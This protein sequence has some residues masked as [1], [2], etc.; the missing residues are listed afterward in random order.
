M[1]QKHKFNCLAQFIFMKK[2]KRIAIILFSLCWLF[3]AKVSAQFGEAHW[4]SA[5]GV[6]DTANTW[7]GFRKEFTLDRLPDEALASVAADSKY[8][9]WVN[10]ELAVFEGG[11][12]RGP[13]PSD[14]YYDQVDISPYLRVGENVIAIKLWFFGKDGFSHKNSG[15][16]GLIF[17]CEAGGGEFRL[18]SDSDW[19]AKVLA[20]YQ[21]V[22]PP[23]PNFRLPES[24][25]LYD[26]RMADTLWMTAK[27]NAVEFPGAIALGRAG[28]TPWNQL[29]PRPIPMWK[30][31]GLREYERQNGKPYVKK[32]DTLICALPYNAQFTPYLSVRA[33]ADQ[34]IV[35]AT[36]NYLLYNGS[37]ENIR[38]E[39]I[40]RDGLQTYESPGWLNGHRM[41]Y[42][43]PEG[44]EVISLKYRETGY[45][46]DFSGSF[47]SDDPFFNTLW[48]KALRTLYVTMRDN[49]MDCPD[50][51]RAQWTG[52]AV[53][54]AEEAFYALDPSSHA[55]A[56]KWLHE[57]VNWQRPDGSLFSPVPAGN[58]DRELPD[59]VL[60]SIG[61]YGIWTY[62]MHTADIETVRLLYPAI[63]RYL[64]LWERDED[65]LVSIREGGWLWGD[66]GENKDMLLIFN[67][68]YYLALR[69]N[70]LM[71]TELGMADDAARYQQYMSLFEKAF[72]E[73]FW[74]GKVYRDPKYKGMTDDRVHALAVVSGIADSSKYPQIMEVFATEEHASPYMEK[75]V[76][77]AMYL[78]GFPEAANARHKKRF[79]AMVSHPYFTTLFEGW[80]IGDEGFGGGTVNHAWS[81]GGLTVL[82]SRVGGIRPLKPGYAEFSV[83]P[84]PGIIRH[85]STS[86][87]SV[88]GIITSEFSYDEDR[89]ILEVTVP[90]GTNA[91]VKLPDHTYRYIS[92]NGQSVFSSLVDE[93]VSDSN[94]DFDNGEW[95]AKLPEGAWRIVG[96][97]DSIRAA[98]FA[99]ETI[100]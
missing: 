35:M 63:Q 60:A 18:Q 45:D 73:R 37:D 85:A 87:S 95:Q 22:P 42:I 10:G 71:A 20:A 48:D 2:E 28:A 47:D 5:P 53:L 13:N 94:I 15:K 59:Q 12:K 99:P 52:D 6:Q 88:R 9:L 50:R 38:A 39:Y 62:Y 31:Y 96:E 90:S 24:S 67:L 58:W 33:S 70:F 8:W 3:G 27:G 78:M 34:R 46:T 14:T 83:S 51:E 81:G 19:S 69:G 26:A 57:L 93:G 98:A 61:Y 75:Y 56:R 65:G 74:R 64:D 21:T 49:Y 1:T 36:D 43:I 54:E 72:N 77:E 91:L 76:F 29:H 11:L 41:Y 84:Q 66:W 44:V 23:V 79:S 7:I 17:H 100:R 82:S 68:W 89:F 30:D 55:L 80:G 4:I 97:Y 40:T 92:I 86:V 16:A 32:G 25:I